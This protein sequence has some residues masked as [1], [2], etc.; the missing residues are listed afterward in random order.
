M[1]AF[2]VPPVMSLILACIVCYVIF[3]KEFKSKDLK[4]VFYAGCQNALLAVSNTSSIYGFGQVVAAAAGFDF[5]VGAL[6][7]H[8]THF[9]ALCI[10]ELFHFRPIFFLISAY[11]G[12][13]HAGI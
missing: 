7:L 10:K 3:F 12:I 6:F 8:Y 13:F 9:F 4:P 11:N 5:I 2:S 1:N